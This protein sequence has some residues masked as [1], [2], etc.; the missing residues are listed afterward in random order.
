LYVTIKESD[1]SEQF[2]VVPYASV[3]VLQREGRLK[4]A[5]TTGVYRAYDN[6]IDKAPLAAGTAIYGLPA[7]Y[8]VYGGGQFSNRYQALALG[9]GKNLGSI[10]AL[11]TDITQAWSQQKNRPREE[12]Q[13][14]R[15]RYSKNLVQ[16][17]TNFTFAG[18]R[19]A[20]SGYWDM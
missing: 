3:P 2:L 17:G 18:Y 19:Y 6:G 4:Y 10:G 11:S 1:G 16:T 20:T 12:G 13:S 7:G 5:M 14:W 9:I 15:I 8:T